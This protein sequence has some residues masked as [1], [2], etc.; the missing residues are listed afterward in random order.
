[1]E[2]LLT[3]H[4]KNGVRKNKTIYFEKNR[5]L[6][7]LERFKKYITELYDKFNAAL[8]SCNDEVEM[9]E[10][11]FSEYNVTL[12]FDGITFS[13]FDD[14]SGNVLN[15]ID[16]IMFLILTHDFYNDVKIGKL[17]FNDCVIKCVEKHGDVKNDNWVYFAFYEISHYGNYFRGNNCII[18]KVALDCTNFKYKVILN[19]LCKDKSGN[20]TELECYLYDFD[21]S[22][23]E[24]VYN[25]VDN[26]YKPISFNKDNFLRMLFATVFD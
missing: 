24:C 22:A 18:T 4:T 10:F 1:M 23:D 7:Y 12:K 9:F 13:F 3:V 5:R 11:N 2:I 19:I 20:E 17:S 14:N 8:L 26:K 15:E 16:E 6:Y 25:D 21:S